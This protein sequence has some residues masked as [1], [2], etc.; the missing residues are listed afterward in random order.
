MLIKDLNRS[1]KTLITRF[2]RGID[3]LTVFA[4]GNN[5][6]GVSFS[7]PLTE[8]EINKLA[9]ILNDS[10]RL[11]ISPTSVTVSDGWTAQFK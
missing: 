11:E 10:G 5:Y 2:T 7:R 1:E 6:S 9:E 3:D 4:S 8:D